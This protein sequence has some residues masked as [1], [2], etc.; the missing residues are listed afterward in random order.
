VGSGGLARAPRRPRPPG[1]PTKHEVRDDASRWGRGRA[2][3]L[4]VRQK[5]EHHLDTKCRRVRRRREPE[6][7]VVQVGLHIRA[8]PHHGPVELREAPGHAVGKRG[9]QADARGDDARLGLEGLIDNGDK[10]GVE[11][12][13]SWR[14]A[15]RVRGC[16]VRGRARAGRGRREGAPRAPQGP[17]G[18]RQPRVG[19]ARGCEHGHRALACRRT[20]FDHG[21]HRT[22]CRRAIRDGVVKRDVDALFWPRQRV[23]HVPGEGCRPAAE[24]K[25]LVPLTA[26]RRSLPA[27]RGRL[28]RRPA[29]GLRAA[30]AC[31]C[32][33][34]ARTCSAVPRRPAP[35]PTPRT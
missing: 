16:A 28:G 14:G 10:D 19:R 32:M 15:G 5:A 3:F 29:S 2:R 25:V 13:I 20:Y 8:G 34:L 11:A 30:A 12:V 21:L 7:P 4:V 9:E 1:P 17:G 31:R 26:S 18:A 35:A 6:R 33:S 22:V 23:G 24:L 27:A